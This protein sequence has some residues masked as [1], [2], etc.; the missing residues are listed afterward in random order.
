MC[1]GM[2]LYISPLGFMPRGC[3]GAKGLRVSELG[4]RCGLR[5]MF[6]ERHVVQ[7]A[8]LLLRQ[9]GQAMGHFKRQKMGVMDEKWSVL[10]LG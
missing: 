10:Q 9:E 4:A 8:S 2:P 1:K 3:E 6:H 5:F 7:L